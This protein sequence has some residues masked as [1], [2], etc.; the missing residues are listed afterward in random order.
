[1]KAL[2]AVSVSKNHKGT[3][4]YC[5]LK[6]PHLSCSFI[7]EKYTC[8]IKQEIREI[9]LATFC[10]VNKSFAVD[11]NPQHHEQKT[12]KSRVFGALFQVLENIEGYF[13]SN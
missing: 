9:I 5:N 6:S 7:I 10:D 13:T 11:L 3:A 4:R 2:Q 12:L 8:Y 1:L